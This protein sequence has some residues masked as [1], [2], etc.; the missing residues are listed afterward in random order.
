[1]LPLVL[2]GLAAGA[3]A[4][5]GVGSAAMQGESNYRARQAR[6]ALKNQSKKTDEQYAQ[7]QEKWNPATQ[8]L[9]KDFNGTN[10][11]GGYRGAVSAYETGKK[12]YADTQE[13]DYDL[14]KGIQ[15]VWDPYFNEKVNLA[16]KQVYGGAANAGKLMSSATAR[17]VSNAVAKQY[18]ESYAAALKAA[19]EQERQEYGWYADQV[20]RE[21]AAIDQY[22]QTLL[23][24]IGNY[25]QLTGTEMGALGQQSE[26][27]KSRISDT[28]NLNVGAINA[29]ATQNNP[30]GAGL[31]SVGQMA[32]QFLSSYLNPS[33]N[34]GRISGAGSTAGN[35]TGIS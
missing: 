25:A 28:T 2:G 14:N 30:V 11:A 22:N 24:N 33:L 4:L 15:Q 6:D 19:Q 5:S 32:G 18:D 9:D 31:S 26:I 7:L 10:G 8:N 3:A 35:T 21:R 1:M 13:W 27:G 12:N 17:N 20:A 23:Q 34:A 29:N 16:A